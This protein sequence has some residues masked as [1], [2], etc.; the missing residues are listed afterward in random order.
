MMHVRF[1]ETWHGKVHKQNDKLSAAQ[2]A[3]SCILTKHHIH[4]FSL[5]SFKLLSNIKCCWTWQEVKHNKTTYLG[6]FKCGRK[7]QTIIPENPHMQYSNLVLFFPKPYFNVVKHARWVHQVNLGIF[8]PHL[9]IKF[10]K[11]GAMVI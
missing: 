9:H 11:F 2:Y 10:I 3:T 7:Q 6:K 5:L 4:L 8:P 1:N